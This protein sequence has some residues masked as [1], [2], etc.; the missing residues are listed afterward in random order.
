MGGRSAAAKLNVESVLPVSRRQGPARCDKSLSE[1]KSAID[2]GIGQVWIGTEVWNRKYNGCAIAIAPS[3]EADQG[4][5]N[6]ARRR[7]HD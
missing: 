2:G 6:G 1:D 5:E 3:A 4:R 7:V